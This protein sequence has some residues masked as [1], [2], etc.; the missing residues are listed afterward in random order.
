M[1]YTTKIYE[2]WADRLELKIPNIEYAKA[3]KML[4]KSYK[5]TPKLSNKT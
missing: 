2:A 5:Y 1:K 3:N 4:I